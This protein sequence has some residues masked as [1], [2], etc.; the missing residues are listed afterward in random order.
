MPKFRR[1]Q[2]IRLFW[3]W[4]YLDLC[5][6]LSWFYHWF[7]SI[8]LDSSE[9]FKSAIISFISRS[10]GACSLLRDSCLVT[11]VLAQPQLGKTKMWGLQYPP[12]SLDLFRAITNN[13][14]ILCSAVSMTM[15]KA[16]NIQNQKWMRYYIYCKLRKA[17]NKK[18]CLLLFHKSDYRFLGPNDHWQGISQQWLCNRKGPFSIRFQV[19]VWNLQ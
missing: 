8:L 4:W 10:V 18:K 11:S 3:T 15:P 12:S 6:R 17:L 16:L 14:I 1:L 5:F 19:V 13:K 9:S 2:R 7:R